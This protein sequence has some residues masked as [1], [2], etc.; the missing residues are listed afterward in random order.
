MVIALE[1]FHFCMRILGLLDNK[2]TYRLCIVGDIEYD[3]I[4]Y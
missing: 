3:T 2:Y 1:A 4:I